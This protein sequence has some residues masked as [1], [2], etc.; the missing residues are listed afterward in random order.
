ME[1][2]LGKGESINLR[3]DKPIQC[4]VDEFDVSQRSSIYL[5]P[6]GH[7]EYHHEM[8]VRCIHETGSRLRSMNTLYSYP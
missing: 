6:D 7:Q 1:R 2:S 8:H 4:H 5:L 3:R